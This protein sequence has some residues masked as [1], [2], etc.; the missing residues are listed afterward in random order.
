MVVGGDRDRGIA[1]LRIQNG[2]GL[3][4]RHVAQQGIECLFLARKILLDI[5]DGP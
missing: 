2:S 4:L 1:E 5:A 3:L